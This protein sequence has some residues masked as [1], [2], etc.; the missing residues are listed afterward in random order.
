VR[1]TVGEAI[2]ARKS[3]RGSWGDTAGR[4]YCPRRGGAC[5]VRAAHASA[6]LPLSGTRGGQG[7]AWQWRGAAQIH[8]VL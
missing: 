3:G 8:L 6:A 1:R 2:P 4:P 7:S 5:L